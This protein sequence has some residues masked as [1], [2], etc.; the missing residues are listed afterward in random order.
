MLLIVKELIKSD[1]N[2]NDLNKKSNR[3]QN[4]DNKTDID[5]DEDLMYYEN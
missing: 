4:N 1:V 3:E 2:F 5:I